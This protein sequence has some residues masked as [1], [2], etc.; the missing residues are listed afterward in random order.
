MTFLCVGSTRS[1]WCRIV[2][3]DDRPEYQR[4]LAALREG[5][6]SGIT[7]YDDSRLNRN[8]EN[9]M[10]LFRECASHA[11]LLRIERDDRSDPR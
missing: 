11:V 2:V 7:A 8:S 3:T 10:R 1:T 4:M 9:A 6:L 5:R